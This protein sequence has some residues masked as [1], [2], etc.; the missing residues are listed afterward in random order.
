MIIK[1]KTESLVYLKE[2]L[3]NGTYDENYMEVMFKNG[4]RNVLRVEIG[5]D[6]FITV[7]VESQKNI[8]GIWNETSRT[9]IISCHHEFL[10]K[11][12]NDSMYRKILRELI[13]EP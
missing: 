3:E 6:P 1:Q 9:D 10:E 5:E 4:T 2:K 13:K 7:Y 12:F 11:N 8:N